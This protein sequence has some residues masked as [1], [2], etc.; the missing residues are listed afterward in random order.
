[1]RFPS[2]SCTVNCRNPQGFFPR[3]STMLATKNISS[4][5]DASIS[6][7]NANA[8]QVQTAAPFS[9]KILAPYHRVTRLQFLF[10]GKAIRFQSRVRLC[11]AVVR[12][13]HRRPAIPALACQLSSFSLLRPPTPSVYAKNHPRQVLALQRRQRPKT[14]I[15]G[16]DISKPSG[17]CRDS[18]FKSMKSPSMSCTNLQREQTRW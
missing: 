15:N 9:E 17:S 16:C 11:N 4:R 13:R 6:S 2:I 18:R 8:R 12:V 5:Y 14:S 3:G 10:L 7:A 1:M